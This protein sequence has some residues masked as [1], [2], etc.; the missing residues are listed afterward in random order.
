MTANVPE[1]IDTAGRTEA[2]RIKPC[3]AD[4]AAAR[5]SSESHCRCLFL[6]GPQRGTQITHGHRV[7]AGS[8]NWR[9]AIKTGKWPLTDPTRFLGRQSEQS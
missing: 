1:V 5:L 9:Y 4:E 7:P 8:R 3:L 6:A 2:G